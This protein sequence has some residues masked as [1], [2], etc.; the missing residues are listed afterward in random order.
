MMN[1]KDFLAVQTKKLGDLQHKSQSAL[2]LV[3]STINGLKSANEEIA[4]TMADIRE[5]QAM[6]SEKESQLDGVKKRNE[7]IV[8]NFSK[9]IEC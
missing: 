1:N 9:L 3:T 2:D 7:R 4:S 5:Y 8:D 6:L